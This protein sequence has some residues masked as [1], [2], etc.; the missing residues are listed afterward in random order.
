M[1]ALGAQVADQCQQGIVIYLT[2]DLG[3]GK[4]TFV[5]GFM[6]AL[7]HTG[8]VKSPT[9][10]LVEHY[11]VGGRKA[12]HFDLY[13]LVDP[14]ELEFMGM[15]DY[16]QPRN[17]CLVEWPE[18]GGEWLPAPDIRVQI[19]YQGEGRQISLQSETERGHLLLASV[20]PS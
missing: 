17:L 19:D 16:F 3:A 14:G 13:R 7:G 15:R 18:R 1:E 11:D 9:Y 5:R 4:T 10:T 8:H 20:S 2:G 12:Y 6:H